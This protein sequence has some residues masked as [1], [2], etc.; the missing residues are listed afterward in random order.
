MVIKSLLLFL[1][2]TEVY[3]RYVESPP[4]NMK[5]TTEIMDA[6][7]ANSFCLDDK[8]FC[9]IEEEI[10]PG[11]K[12]ETWLMYHIY[13]YMKNPNKDQISLQKFIGKVKFKKLRY[14]FD[15]E[16][17]FWIPP[18][19]NNKGEDIESRENIDDIEII[20]YFDDEM[21]FERRYDF[22][23]DIPPWWCP[24]DPGH[25]KIRKCFPEMFDYL[26][27]QKWIEK[28]AHES[29]EEKSEFVIDVSQLLGIG[30]EGIVVRRPEIDGLQTTGKF[31]ALKIM[32]LG[33]YTQSDAASIRDKLNDLRKKQKN[34]CN[35]VIE[36]RNIDLDYVV[37]FGSK[38]LVLVIGM[39]K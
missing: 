22:E 5:N 28:N 33:H 20:V 29:N 10:K 27:D 35:G 6:K 30:G 23:D 7:S 18:R 1:F 34:G 14:K 19:K 4:Q 11:K 9:R 25:K 39:S 16:Y 31:S 36:F 8:I 15:D 24:K 2:E 32:P 12:I 21:K 37:N 3:L 17:E 26:K 13:R 38:I